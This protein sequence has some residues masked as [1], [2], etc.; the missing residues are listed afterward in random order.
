MIDIQIPTAYQPAFSFLPYFG[1]A[2]AV[3]F[4]ITPIVGYIARKFR[5]I[6]LPASMRRGD[7]PSDYRHLEKQP[8]PLLGGVAV[9]LPFLVLALIHT[10]LT[11]TVSYLLL[12]TSLLFAMG[13]I[14]DMFE[15]PGWVQLLT[16]FFV[17]LLICLS[18]INISFINNP[19]GQGSINLDLLSLTH[20]LGSIPIDLV[21]PGDILLGAWILICIN[22]VKWMSGTD[23]LMEGNSFIG[24]TTLFIVALRFQNDTVA[25]Y[26]I[27]LAG[28]LLGFL[29]FN[30]YPAKIWSGSPGKSTLGFLLA[31]LSVMLG[32]KFAAG[33]IILMLPLVDFVWV[34]VGRIIRHKPKNVLHM[35]SISDKTHLHHRLL[36]HGYSERHIAFFEYMISIALG[37]LTLALSGALKASIVIFIVLIVAV[38]LSLT[39]IVSRHRQEVA[40]EK[41]MERKS[42]EARYS[43]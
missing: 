1:V 12:G 34:L 5:I 22:A 25:A 33:L 8:T 20:N 15:L 18:P 28:C 19:F 24:F 9:I 41:K 6:A 40:R 29:F 37:S 21:L 26:S 13:V 42:P 16:Q 7:K 17:A 43:Y 10:K 35:L 30:F 32:A 3:S 39:S 2:F 11:P 36:A 27:I 14:D 38:I 31:V 23:G 4:V